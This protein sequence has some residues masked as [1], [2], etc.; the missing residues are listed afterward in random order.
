MGGYFITSGAS[1]AYYNVDVVLAHIYTN[2][3][4]SFV[5]L[6]LQCSYGHFEDSSELSVLYYL[7]YTSAPVYDHAVAEVIV[8]LQVE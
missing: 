6:H 3:L 4:A 2:I 1:L 7:V 5:H 8:T